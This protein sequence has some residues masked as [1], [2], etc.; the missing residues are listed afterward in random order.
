MGL[1]RG[2]LMAAVLLPAVFAGCASEATGAERRDPDRLIVRAFAEDLDAD[3]TKELHIRLA[4][5]SGTHVHAFTGALEVLLIP[6]KDRAWVPRVWR[7]DIAPHDFTKAALPY[8]EIEADA[9]YLRPGEG[10][11]VRAEARLQ[12]GALLV[13]TYQTMV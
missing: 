1:V 11:E 13:G 12:S 10:I 6:D 4:A 3:G 8:F 9:P 5:A 2:L 7:D